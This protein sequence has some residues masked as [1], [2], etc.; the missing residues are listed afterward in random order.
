MLLRSRFLILT[1]MLL[2]CRG[3][4]G[5]LPG[6]RPEQDLAAKTVA[7]LA[8]LKDRHK[9]L[10]PA[11]TYAVCFGT[12]SS[13]V[14]LT[15]EANGQ[16][17]HRLHTTTGTK[18]WGEDK[19]LSENE[20]VELQKRFLELPDHSRRDMPI[21]RV[22]I[23]SYPG[24]NGRVIKTCDLWNLPEALEEIYR[25][26]DRDIPRWYPG[27]DAR[28]TQ[29]KNKTDSQFADIVVHP[30]KKTVLTLSRHGGRL[31]QWSPA[32]GEVHA[33][34]GG[35]GSVKLSGN[36]RYAVTKTSSGLLVL[37][38]LDKS[39][40]ALEMED[41][42]D[43]DCLDASLSPDGSLL[44]ARLYKRLVIYDVVTLKPKRTLVNDTWVYSPSF[45]PDGKTIAIGVA[46][47][48]MLMDLNSGEHL[49][50]LVA[51]TGRPFAF[52]PD[53][54][55]IAVITWE[56]WKR[57]AQ[58]TVSTWAGYQV[59]DVS[60]PRE[61]LLRRTGEVFASQH[62][63][64]LVWTP[65]SRTIAIGTRGDWSAPAWVIDVRSGERLAAISVDVRTERLA[66]LA[67]GYTLVSLAGSGFEE[68]KLL[69]CSI[70]EYLPEHRREQKGTSTP[71]LTFQS[72]EAAIAH[73]EAEIVKVK[74]E[75]KS[76]LQSRVVIPNRRCLAVGRLADL[77]PAGYPAIRRLLTTSDADMK[78]DVLMGLHRLDYKWAFPLVIE[79]IRDARSKEH[80]ATGLSL[81]EFFEGRSFLPKP[82]QTLDEARQALLD[83]WEKEGK[84]RYGSSE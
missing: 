6:A 32:D 23:A 8:E 21:E 52:S 11:D 29:L 14:W 25:L 53:G 42:R 47:K 70:K 68:G 60:N 80:I 9:N 75:R 67:D 63:S 46:N 2:S 37:D 57:H 84:A 20:M 15:I 65:D 73:C 10:Q 3:P 40:R 33:E 49:S 38:L 77:G 82:E 71:L 51:H 62:V 61:P 56:G 79:E 45:C 34:Y 81:A 22:A 50:S 28:P 30:D 24:A 12:L 64:D 59:H 36:G 18:G 43:R 54:K 44:A 83:W 66:V 48:V 19:K 58:G 39:T 1:L 35:S 4:S 13:A 78:T 26:A 74:P 5:E 55:M 76:F 7:R 16:T 72:T 69:A 41:A 27:A 17:W 31:C